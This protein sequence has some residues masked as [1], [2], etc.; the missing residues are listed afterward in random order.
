MVRRTVS[1]GNLWSA[2]TVIREQQGFWT[3]WWSLILLHISETYP[4]A[5]ASQNRWISIRLNIIGNTLS[6]GLAAY[7]VYFQDESAANTGFSLSMAGGLF[8]LFCDIFLLTSF[9]LAGFS[10]RV[11]FWV[12][13][14]Y[15]IVIIFLQN[16]WIDMPYPIG[17]SVERSP[18]PR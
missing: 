11:L 6:A 1:Y 4:L 10:M 17:S 9:S 2:S 13:T 14:L 7:L 12:C 3:T 5:C 18:N 8:F 15:P 16:R